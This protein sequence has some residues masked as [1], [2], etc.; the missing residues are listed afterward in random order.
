M[1]TEFLLKYTPY[2]ERLGM[3]ENYLD[4]SELVECRKDKT[5]LIVA[6]HVFGDS[7]QDSRKKIY[8]MYFKIVL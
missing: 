7:N 1:Q 8:E 3:D 4:V 5:P 6:G 2:V